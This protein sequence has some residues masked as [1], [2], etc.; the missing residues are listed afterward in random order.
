M[1]QRSTRDQDEQS[2]RRG[3]EVSNGRRG[4]EEMLKIVEDQEESTPVQ[5]CRQGCRNRLP[6]VMSDAECPSDGCHE[7]CW[8]VQRG[9]RHKERSVWESI[10]RGVR[11]SDC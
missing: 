3:N 1:K 7:W 6:L 4:G 5:V 11:R 8:T 10:E 9:Q 2:G